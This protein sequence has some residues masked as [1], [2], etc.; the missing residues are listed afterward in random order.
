MLQQ[1]K[2]LVKPRLLRSNP[3]RFS[4]II[5]LDYDP[6]HTDVNDN[7]L[8]CGYGRKYPTIDADDDFDLDDD[9]VLRLFLIRLRALEAFDN[10]EI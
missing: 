1:K 2:K 3:H 8:H 6:L 10:R 5:L 9:I 4:K 7:N